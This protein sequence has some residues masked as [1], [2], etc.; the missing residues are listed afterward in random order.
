MIDQFEIFSNF[1][2]VFVQRPTR[3]I[4]WNVDN[5]SNCEILEIRQFFQFKK[6]TNLQ[7][8]KLF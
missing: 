3:P 5:F 7:I 8:R 6:L 2:H 4:F 1:Q